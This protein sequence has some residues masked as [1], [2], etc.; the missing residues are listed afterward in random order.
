MCILEQIR[1][2]K[3]LDELAKIENDYWKQH[4]EASRQG[5]P[6]ADVHVVVNWLGGKKRQLELKEK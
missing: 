6:L 4:D 2:A 3:S 5:Y 1:D